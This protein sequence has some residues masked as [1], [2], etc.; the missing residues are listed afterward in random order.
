MVT[1]ED[2]HVMRKNAERLAEVI[3][4]LLMSVLLLGACAS[5]PRTSMSQAR[6][7]DGA[8]EQVERCTDTCWLMSA[9]NENYFEARVYIRGQRVATLPGMTAKQVAI[10]ITR[11]M[12]DAA[13]CMVIFVQLSPDTK[14]AYS[15]KEC[16]VPG[17]RLELAVGNSYGEHPL[18]LWLNEWRTR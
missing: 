17:S 8:P 18:R 7:F 14:T 13:G 3:I 4:P 2:A 5:M 9:R 16:P 12:L 15:S 6:G 1:A 11:S 10:P